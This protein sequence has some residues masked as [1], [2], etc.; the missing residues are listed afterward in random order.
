M[1]TQMAE[2]Y[3]AAAQKA[4]G[5]GPSSAYGVASA[6]AQQDARAN[7]ASSTQQRMSFTVKTL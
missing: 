5:A 3:H 7:P 6:K 1:A 2:R 4:A